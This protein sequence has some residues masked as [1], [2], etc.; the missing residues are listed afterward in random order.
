MLYADIYRPKADGKY[1]VLLQR[2]PYNKDGGRGFGLK[3]RRAAT[4]SSSRTCADATPRKASGTRSSTSRTTATTRSSGRRRCRT[5][6]ARSGCSAARTSARRR[7]SRRSR[8]RRTLQA[9]ARSSRRATTTRTGRIRAARSSSGSIESWTTGLAQDTYRAQTRAQEQ[10]ARWARWQL[11]LGSYPAVQSGGRRSGRPMPPRRSRRTTSTGSRIPNYDDYWKQWSIEEH[12][13]DIT[14]P[15]LHIVAWYDIFSGRLAPQLHRH[16]GARR[17]R[18]GAERPAPDR[19]RRRPCGQRAD[20]R[21]CGFRSRVEVRRRRRDA[22]LV[23]LPVQG[24][25]ER[26]RAASR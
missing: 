20:G 11:P 3:P 10:R 7:C 8:T 14:V 25:A 2:T 15:A 26:V 9:S 4:S 21:R 6:T 17:H 18:R 24:R 1:P 23:R 5:R 12:F 16:Q 22:R 19:D 13:A